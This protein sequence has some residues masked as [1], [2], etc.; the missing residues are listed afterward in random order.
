MCESLYRSPPIIGEPDKMLRT[1]LAIMALL[2]PVA[3][4]A[5]SWSS[6]DYNSNN[7]YSNHAD[8]SG[9]TTYGSNLNNGAQW[10]LRQNYDGTYNGLDSDGNYFSGNNNTGFY[11]NLGTGVTCFGTGAF[12]TCN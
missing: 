6:Y 8:T 3:S 9:V 1:S 12:R 10:Q 11:Q 7:Y 5:Q 2:S 4:H